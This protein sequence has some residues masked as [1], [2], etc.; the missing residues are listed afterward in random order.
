MEHFS[1]SEN[2]GHF[3]HFCDFENPEV[4]E[5]QIMVFGSILDDPFWSKNP[6]NHCMYGSQ[7]VNHPNLT[8]FR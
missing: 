1:K 8:H 6:I 5:V 3:D 4:R 2:L 7:E